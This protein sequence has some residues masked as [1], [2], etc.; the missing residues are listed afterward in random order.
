MMR[1]LLLPAILACL[2]PAAPVW[3]AG[4]PGAQPDARAELERARAEHDRAGRAVK[5]RKA[6]LLSRL[7]ELEAK[8]DREKTALARMEKQLAEAAA[9]RDALA[10]ERAGPSQELKEVAVVVR[11]YAR[12]MLALTERSPVLAENPDA[13]AVLKRLAAARI[14]PGP[15]DLE[16]LL[17]ISLADMEASGRI[18]MYNGT[19]VN[20]H[21]E[22][23]SG[24]ICRVGHMMAAYETQRQTGYLSISPASGRLLAA[25]DPPWWVE[26][27]LKRFSHGESTHVFMDLSG[28]GVVRRLAHRRTLTGWLKSGGPLVW[29]IILVG[30]IAVLLLIERLWFLGRV[31]HNTDALMTRVTDLVS[32]GDLEGAV[33][34]A[35]TYKG[36][37]TG[38]VLL[39]GLSQHGRPR[40]MIESGLS[41]AILRETPR[42][43]RFLTAL[44]VLAA[45]APLLGL[46]GTVTGMINTFQ[47]ITLH[48]AEDPRLMAGGISEALITTQ[49]GLAVA[50][51]IMIAAAFLSRRA[52]NRLTDMEEK[53]LALISA[54]LGGEAQ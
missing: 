14:M 16:Q 13:L 19:F 34:E 23:V 20:R 35:R 26:R 42:L 17:E 46:L 2:W 9:A 45:V 10:G 40:D 54:L 51:P 31:R 49:V 29:P 32:A 24:R 41:E 47:V 21:G 48:G 44:K 43:E 5:E 25:G 53:A 3:A 7:A 6:R 36:T 30:L 8:R 33:K 27:A 18:V 39:A 12:D 38:N 22:E 4:P 11:E 1:V 15:T 28:G 37:P 52:Q 50:I